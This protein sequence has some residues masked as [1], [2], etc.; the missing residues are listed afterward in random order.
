MKKHLHI[1]SKVENITFAE[2]LIEEISEQFDIKN[3]V[4]GNILVSVMEAVNNAVQHGNKNDER[5]SVDIYCS[6]TDKLVMFRIID[7]GPGFK[8]NDIPD[9]TKPENIEKTSGRGIFLMNHLADEVSFSN[10]GRE[11][12]LKFNI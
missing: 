5:K 7:E 8:F 12:Q 3:D 6:V 11:V 10:E 9:P 1:S 2:N 4:Y